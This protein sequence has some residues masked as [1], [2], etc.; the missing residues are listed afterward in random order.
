MKC[1]LFPLAALFDGITRLRNALFDRGL[2]PQRQFPC[3]VIGVGNLAVGGTGKT[4]HTEAIVRLLLDITSARVAILSRGYGRHTRGFRWVSTTDDVTGVGDEPLQMRRKLPE[5]RV[6]CAVC[7]DRCQ[8]IG[9]LLHAHPDLHAIVLDDAFQHRHVRPH[10]NILLTEHAHLYTADYLLPMGRLREARRGARRAHLIIVTKCP[11]TLTEAERS[12]IVRQLNP[13]SEQQILFTTIA[14]TAVAH[15]PSALLIT[16]IAHPEPLAVHLRAQ[17][18]EIEHMAFAD[19]HAFSPAEAERISHASERHPTIFTT[20]KDWTRLQ[21]LTLPPKVRQK[22]Q[23]IAIAPQF[24][25]DGQQSLEHALRA[26]L[27]PIVSTPS[28]KPYN[29]SL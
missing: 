11:P 4:P 8:G 25:F 6:V 21:Q 20:E 29:R 28:P 13:H 7:E 27:H 3:P 1:L 14:Y 18:I 2:L 17:G 15:T 23:P 9:H 16:G 22:M 24:L 5:E 12:A 19:H 26:T 10:L